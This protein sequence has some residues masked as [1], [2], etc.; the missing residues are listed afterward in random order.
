[1]SAGR[2]ESQQV[3]PVLWRR[4]QRRFGNHHAARQLHEVGVPR[5][6]FQIA[7]EDDATKQETL[8]D[9]QYAQRSQVTGFPTVIGV[10]EGAQSIALTLGF[11][12]W[13][14]VEPTLDDWLSA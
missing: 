11:R 2:I 1:M 10:T 9:F 7:F 13:E 12:A 3:F 14:G 6:D 8:A 4:L 5:G